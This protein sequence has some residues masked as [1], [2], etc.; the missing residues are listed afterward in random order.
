MNPASQPRV[1]LSY[2]L[3]GLPLA[4]LGVPLYVYLPPFYAE[5][6]GLGLAAVGLALMLTR[7]FD[8]ITDPLIG[9][10]ADRLPP[11]HRR[12][13][14]ILIGTPLLLFA[15]HRLLQ[16]PMDIGLGY[17]YGWAVLAYLG[18]T[19]VTL[20]YQ[21]WGAEVDPSAHGRTRLAASR[22]GFAIFGIVLAASLPVLISSEDPADI[23]PLVDILM[24]VLLPLTLLILF[25]QVPEHRVTHPP[26][27]WRIG[28]RLIKRN[29]ALRALLGAYFLNNLANG[30][31]AALFLLFVTYRLEAQGAAGPLL[32][33]YFLAGILALPGWTWAAR[34]H[35][36]RLVWLV[37][38]L[39]ASAAFMIVPWLGPGDVMAFALVCL[40]SGL[41]L[42]ADMA[43]P[44]SIQAD[45]AG[46][47]AE[48]GGGERAGLF[49]GLL[50][51]VTK[52]AL[53]IAVG[54]SFGL[55]E[56]AGFSGEDGDATLALALLY[57]L[58]PVILKLAGGWLIWQPLGKYYREVTPDNTPRTTTAMSKKQHVTPGGTP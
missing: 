50:G 20:P 51:L 57:G 38:V 18:W 44:A 55:L 41:S 24:L 54:L 37:S 5:Q 40:I 49:F 22:E 16:P 7:L 15:L 58:L 56:L 26:V 33:L 2:G 13:L 19:M 6:I 45:L 47:D 35:G 30:L 11:A 46:Q 48:A 8:V 3:P 25:W 21:A 10:L 29:H 23:L 36:K 52:L 1:W 17:L 43:L 12:R 9:H 27:P 32:L 4:L 28:W 42:G 39:L 53:A 34:R 14:M 31:P